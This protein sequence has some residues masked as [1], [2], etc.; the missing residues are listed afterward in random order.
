MLVLAHYEGTRNHAQRK[1]PDTK[2]HMLCEM[3]GYI[4]TYMEIYIQDRQINR[5][6]SLVVSRGSMRRH[7]TI[8]DGLLL[9]IKMVV[10]I[11]LCKYTKNHWHV[12]ILFC[13]ETGSLVCR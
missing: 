1:K 13:F 3:Y 2:S 6:N 5:I 4:Y 8:G 12:H 9:V 11:Q 10:V 7:K